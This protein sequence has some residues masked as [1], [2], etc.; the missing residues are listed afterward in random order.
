MRVNSG[1]RETGWEDIA[2]NEAVCKSDL[3][4]GDIRRNEESNSR[5]T[6]KRGST[7]F[8]PRLNVVGGGEKH[9]RQRLCWGY[10][11]DTAW[12]MVPFT[13]T[14]NVGGGA[15]FGGGIYWGVGKWEMINSLGTLWMDPLHST[16]TIKDVQ[17]GLD[18]V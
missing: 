17:A 2:P 13:L 5:V 14:G 18:Y 6:W 3:D 1:G 7:G 12:L 8:C 11:L 9:T 4:L 10:C 15:H 16:A